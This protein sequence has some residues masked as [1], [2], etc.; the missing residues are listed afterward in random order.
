MSTVL[1]LTESVAND[2]LNDASITT[3][4]KMEMVARVIR[5]PLYRSISLNLRLIMVLYYSQLPKRP[6]KLV[7]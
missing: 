1:I 6:G 3:K 7:V 4:S 5:I 2:S